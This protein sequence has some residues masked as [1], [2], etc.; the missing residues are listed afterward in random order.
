MPEILK[1]TADGVKPYAEINDGEAWFADLMARYETAGT[2][3]GEVHAI[4]PSRALALLARNPDNRKISRS[5]MKDFVHDIGAGLWKFNGEAIIIADVGLLNDGQHRL[6][7]VIATGKT[8][9]VMVVVGVPRES[10]M[11]LDVGKA[12][13]VAD[14]LGMQGVGRRN[15]IAA[16]AEI[17]LAVEE[18]LL[19]ALPE[20]AE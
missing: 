10:R 6:M 9:E 17:P 20:I 5:V 14:F 19:G 15:D 4:S 18:G 12:R 8:I 16:V 3:I 7:A 13:T 11:T 2:V 1:K